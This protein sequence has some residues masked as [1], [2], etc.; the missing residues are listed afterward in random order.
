MKTIC[1]LACFILVLPVATTSTLV[2]KDSSLQQFQI[3]KQSFF[4]KFL[5]DFL[6]KRFL[7]SFVF[8]AISIIFCVTCKSRFLTIFLTL[9]SILV[10]IA[11]MTEK[12]L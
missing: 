10:V 4:D 1:F 12:N 8:V 11:F 3:Q 2:C 5:N 7:P 9:L 6:P